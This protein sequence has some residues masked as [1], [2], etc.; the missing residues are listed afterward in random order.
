MDNQTTRRAMLGATGLATVALIAPALAASPAPTRSADSM[1]FSAVLDAADAA[2]ER[3]N[4]LPA[5][6]EAMQGALYERELQCMLSTSRRGDA[7]VPTTW[8][9]YAR[10]LEHVSDEGMS[11]IDEDNVERLLAHTRRLLNGEA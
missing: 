8:E 6:T 11:T 9:E 10:W 2:R 7:A 5:D 4:A 3:F 1:A